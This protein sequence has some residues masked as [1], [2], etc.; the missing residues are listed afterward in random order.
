[1]VKLV[2][3]LYKKYKELVHYLI[4][5]VLTTLVSWITYYVCVEWI[6]NP[7]VSWQLQSAVILRWLSGVIF[8]YFT[9]RKY[10]FESKNQNLW[11]EGFHF[12]SSR[13]LTL[14]MDMFVMWFMVTLLGINDWVST[15]VSAVLVT[16]TNYFLS[17]F[18]VFK[19][20]KKE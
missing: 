2:L 12:A 10:V 14:F 9:N 3:N 18:L 13:L 19:K 1:M 4:V 17:K 7:N 15:L 20:T 8:A 16:I 6:F 11:K 5:G